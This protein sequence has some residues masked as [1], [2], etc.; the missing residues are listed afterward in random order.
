MDRFQRQ[1]NPDNPST[2]DSSRRGLARSDQYLVM[3]IRSGDQRPIQGNATPVLA[4]GT[5]DGSMQQRC[6]RDSTNRNE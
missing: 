1:V 5:F 3:I 2:L 6:R 4:F